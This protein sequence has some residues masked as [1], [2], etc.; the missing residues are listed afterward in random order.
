MADV[1][2]VRALENVVVHHPDS[3]MPIT[4]MKN[5]IYRAD[6]A[7]VVQNPSLFATDEQIYGILQ[8]P[9]EQATMAPGERRNLRRP[10]R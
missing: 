1:K 10:N 8:A 6:D 5:D 2:Y 4:L 3:G 9:V 7:M